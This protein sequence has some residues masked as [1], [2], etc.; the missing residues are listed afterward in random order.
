MQIASLYDSLSRET[1]HPYAIK[2]YEQLGRDSRIH[3]EL[4]KIITY[5]A[6]PDRL[7]ELEALS[8]QPLSLK[9]EGPEIQ[10]LYEAVTSHLELE[11]TMHREYLEMR[12]RVLQD[13]KLKNLWSVLASWEEDHHKF[14]QILKQALEREYGDALKT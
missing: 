13:E 7:K 14:L 9:L 10:K 3:A 8:I 4:L 2:L 11:A 12:D 6:L 5:L 1:T